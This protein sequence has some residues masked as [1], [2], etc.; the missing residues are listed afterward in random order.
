VESV[1]VAEQTSVVLKGYTTDPEIVHPGDEVSMSVELSCTGANAYD[2]KSTLRFDPMT[3]ISS[4]GPSLV[5][6][7]DLEPGEAVEVPYRL[8][9]DGGLRAGQYPASLTVTYLDSDGIPRSLV[10]SVTLSVRGIVDFTLINDE[11][12]SVSAGEVHTF[13]ADLLLVGTESVQFVEIEVVGDTVFDT[14]SGSS[15]YIGAVDP[16]SPVPFDLS[17]EVD[18]GTE[19]GEYTLNLKVTYKDDLNQEI[20]DTVELSVSVGEPSPEPSSTQGSSG[21]FWGWLRRILGLG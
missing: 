8:L 19:P 18:E 20:E 4:L 15:E 11:G 17:F 16:D 2:V 1:Q 13:E 10:E 21:G 9:L 14:V 5:A 7:G 6:S 12:E 3:G